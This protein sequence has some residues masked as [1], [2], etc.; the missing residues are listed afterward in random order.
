MLKARR[1]FQ[2]LKLGHKAKDCPSKRKCR[3]CGG[4]HHQTLCSK[5]NESVAPLTENGSQNTTTAAA[6]SGRKTVLLQ[7]AKA[8]VYGE[9]E[10]RKMQIIILFD[11]GSQRSYVTDHLKKKLYLKS[12]HLEVLNLSTFGSENSDRKTCAVVKLTV[13]VDGQPVCISALSHP[14]ICTPLSSRVNVSE[15]AHLR[16][17]DLAHSANGD[18]KRID[19]LI[20][21][22]HYHDFVLDEVIS[23]TSG[24]VAI[25]SKLGWLLSGPCDTVADFN[26]ST[27]VSSNLAIDRSI[28]VFDIA[29]SDKDHSDNQEIVSSLKTFW[30]HE[31]LGVLEPKE[32]DK[33]TGKTTDFDI[34]FNGTRYEVSLPWRD[35]FSDDPLP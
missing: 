11:G 12:E 27:N 1:C 17:L 15:Y 26:I 18:C 8:Y 9:D 32:C 24:P 22:D 28:Q 30:T 10:S 31:S 3:K 35:D 29:D 34:K 4:A 7:T 25:R 33:A 21:A 20:G 19:L 16:G 23:G 2:C 14:T 5:Q 6:V 13:E